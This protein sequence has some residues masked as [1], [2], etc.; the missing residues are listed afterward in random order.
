MEV[1]IVPPD[2]ARAVLA[3]V[4]LIER[5]ITNRKTEQILVLAK[6]IGL[7]WDSA[8]ELL[9]LQ[10]GVNGSSTPELDQCCATFAR[11]QQ[12][13]ARKAL[14]FYRLRERAAAT[15]Y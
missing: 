11:L 7:G 4:G 1:A 2:D 3:E 15:E 9:L 5:A 14:Q 6:A 13:T 8:R 10:A 12:D